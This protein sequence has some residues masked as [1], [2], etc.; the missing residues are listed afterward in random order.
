MSAMRI[1]I[2]DDHGLFR[3]GLQQLLQELDEAPAIE[4]AATLPEVMARLDR[5]DEELDVILFDLRMPGV[6]S[7]EDLRQVRR[8]APA[9]P[10][11]VVSASEAPDDIRGAMQAG[12]AGFIPKSSSAKVM[13]GALKLVLQSGG[14]YVPPTI[15]ESGDEAQAERAAPSEVDTSHAPLTKRQIDVLSLLAEGKSNRQIAEDLEIAEGTVKV[16]VAAILKILGV[17]SRAQAAYRA[18]SRGFSSPAS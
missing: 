14:T 4:H 17:N 9:T 1:L 11:V 2:A 8:R 10:V 7:L 18:R 12:A 13:L 15:L 16:H 6:H 5:E 3:E